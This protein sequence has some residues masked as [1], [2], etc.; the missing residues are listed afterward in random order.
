[1]IDISDGLSTDLWHILEESG[2]GAVIQSSVL[3][4]ANCLRILSS[5]EP[6]FDPLTIALHGGEE[7]ELLFTSPLESKAQLL[8]V[9][10][11]HRVAVTAI[12]EVVVDPGLRLEHEGGHELIVPSGWEHRI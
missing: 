12:G 8:E 10:R 11:S 1:M 5:N 3:P 4:I 9:A 6:G 7:Y 2:C